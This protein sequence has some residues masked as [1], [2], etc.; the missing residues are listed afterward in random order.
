MAL[1]LGIPLAEVEAMPYRHL[2]LLERYWL[3]E[4]WGAWRDNAHAG[5]VASTIANIFR[6][7][8]TRAVSFEQFMF[9]DRKAQRSDGMGQLLK[10]L[11][12]QARPRG[13]D[14][15]GPGKAG[16]SA[17]GRNR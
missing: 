16:G 9:A 6:K 2:R 11:Q 4:P 15:G 17:R 12:A 5:L 14:N 7:K 10:K 3:E 13:K 8:G 1:G